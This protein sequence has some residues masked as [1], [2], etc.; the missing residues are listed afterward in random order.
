MTTGFPNPVHVA[1][2]AGVTHRIRVATNNELQ[3]IVA[4]CRLDAVHRHH[5]V[6]VPGD[7]HVVDHSTP[8]AFYD[9][10][11][12]DEATRR[13]CKK[14]YRRLMRQKQT[15]NGAHRDTTHL[16]VPLGDRNTQ[17]MIELVHPEPP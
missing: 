14:N 17:E 12:Y 6:A 11:G 5:L 8:A 9:A 10:V 16:R 15:P 13:L 4:F 3:S 2:P 7:N 1:G